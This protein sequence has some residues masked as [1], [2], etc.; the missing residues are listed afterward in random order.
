MLIEEL[1]TLGKMLHKEGRFLGKR[2]MLGGGRA[3]SLSA[4]ANDSTYFFPVVAS[5]YMSSD[6]LVMVVRALER[7]YAMFARTAFALIPA[8]EVDSF[9]EA[10][11][12]DYL[13]QFHTNIGMKP[14]FALSFE[15]SSMKE[16]TE[17]SEFRMSVLN[18]ANDD[19]GKP[20]VTQMDSFNQTKPFNTRLKPD[21][22]DSTYRSTSAGKQMFSDLDWKKANELLPTSMQVPVKFVTKSDTGDVTTNIVE[23]IVNVKA[24]MHKTPSGEMVRD[25]ASSLLEKKG[26]LK[27]VKYI[28]GE[29]DS[30]SDFLFG[31]SQMKFDLLNQKA[32]PWIEAFKRRKRLADLAWGTLVN[33]FKPIATICLTMNEVNMLSTKYN[34]DVFKEAE[35][36]MKTYYLLGFVI[37][38]QV[39]EIVYTQFDSQPGFQEYPYKTLEREA[40]NQDR[41]LKDMLKAMNAIR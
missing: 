41:V 1:I 8:V 33:N 19:I 36:I 20:K 34:I 21:Q 26:F 4:L 39:N 31:V 30:T 16:S 27:F 12:R 24:T 5:E 9:D 40:A 18:E 10:T 22:D 38:D 11:V 32:S 13:S 25:V 7:A 6:E 28:S 2:V 17:S 37:V 15:I 23:I 3:K 35:K 29:D 14:N